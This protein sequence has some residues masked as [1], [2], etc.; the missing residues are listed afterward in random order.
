MDSSL[1]K[2]TGNSPV[3][4]KSLNRPAEDNKFAAT[5]YTSGIYLAVISS[6]F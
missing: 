5:F 2:D 1:S 6:I 3:L 4:I